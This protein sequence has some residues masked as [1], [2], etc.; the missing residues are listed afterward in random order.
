MTQAGC[1]SQMTYG[2]MT[3][4]MWN[5]YRKGITCIEHMG[6]G[7]TEKAKPNADRYN[8]SL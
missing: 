2:W 1:L 5:I 3:S 6:I 4:M 7:D 8:V